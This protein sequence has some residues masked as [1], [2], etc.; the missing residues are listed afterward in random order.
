[1]KNKTTIILI[2]IITIFMLLSFVLLYKFV[3]GFKL[4]SESKFKNISKNFSDSSIYILTNSNER[5]SITEREDMDKII[6]YLN[7]T[8][9]KCATGSWIGGAY[10]LIITNN[11]TNEETKISIHPAQIVISGSRYAIAEK[12]QNITYKNVEQIIE[13]Y[14]NDTTKLKS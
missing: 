13:K 4:G 14:V 3:I 6:Q 8:K 2:T 7:D 9:V 5:I 10:S 11:K 1:M 12:Y